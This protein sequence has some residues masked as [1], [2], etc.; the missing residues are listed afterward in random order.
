MIGRFELETGD[1]PRARMSYEAVRPRLEEI[2]LD[3]RGLPT[4]TAA[5]ELAVR[6]EDV[7]V[8]TGLRARLTPFDGLMIASA[9]GAVGPVAYF[10]SRV[11]RLLGDLDSAVDHAAAAAALAAR[12]GFGPWSARSRLAHAQA[13]VAR[14]ASGDRERARQ[15][16]TLA[17]TG[18]R[19]LGMHRLARAGEALL[20]ELS[21][22]GL[23]STREREIAGLVAGGS[24]NRE[25]ALRLVLS[26]RTVETHVQNILTKLGFRSRTQIAAWAAA[27]AIAGRTAT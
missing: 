18:S 9:L 7:D 3:R 6:F 8:A 19:Q 27:E 22:S 12:G 24:T 21:G 20:E 13:L 25:I 4:L 2:T 11:D 17:L 14:R 1:E 15:S 26:D 16:A 5:L 23:L 10:L